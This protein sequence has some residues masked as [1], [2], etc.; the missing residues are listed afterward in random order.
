[1]RVI[2]NSDLRGVCPKCKRQMGVNC[3][4]M[5][6]EDGGDFIPLPGWV[7]ASSVVEPDAETELC[8]DCARAPAGV[9]GAG[10]SYT[11]KDLKAGFVP[12]ALCCG[13]DVY[14][15]GLCYRCY[16]ERR[17]EDEARRRNHD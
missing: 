5:T 13:A 15:H 2:H 7:E 16:T 8:V 6:H 10:V 14:R 1:M 11:A 3:V 9:D 12:K 17:L 4:Q